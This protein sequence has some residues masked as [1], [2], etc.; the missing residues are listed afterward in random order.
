MTSNIENRTLRRWPHGKYYKCLTNLHV[1]D[2]TQ[3]PKPIYTHA[4]QAID[5]STITAPRRCCCCCY[6]QAV[7]SPFL[8]NNQQP[9]F[10]PPPIA[11]PSPSP[12]NVFRLM[13][14][15]MTQHETDTRTRTQLTSNRCGHG[16]RGIGQCL[17]VDR[18]GGVIW[19]VRD[20]RTAVRTQR[21][22]SASD[23]CYP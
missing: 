5:Q 12:R 11:A 13:Y 16:R 6:C 8:R 1:N 15:K 14:L 9:P 22:K 10:S 17:R 3:C 18:G 2:T 7:L 21:S 4:L 20:Y 23:V 19:L